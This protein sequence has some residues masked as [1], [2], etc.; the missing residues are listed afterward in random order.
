MSPAT[1]DRYVKPVKDA[2]RLT[3]VS[4]T[5]PSPLLRSSIKIRTAGDEVEAAPGFFEGDTAAHCG[6]TLKGEF[7][8]TLNLTDVNTGWTFT[9]SIRHN[10]SRHIIAGLN[11]AIDALPR[12]HSLPRLPQPRPAH[13]PDPHH[14]NPAHRHRSTLH[15]RPSQ[16]APGPC[17]HS[18]HQP[19]NQTNQLT[20]PPTRSRG[21]KHVRH[22]NNFAGILT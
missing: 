10:A 6:P 12:D 19:R 14:P 15:P 18:H 3:G 9:T 17:E 2:G 13:T 11:R 1:I 20:R 7:A 4:T 16:P 5:K 22:R 8:R 21:Q